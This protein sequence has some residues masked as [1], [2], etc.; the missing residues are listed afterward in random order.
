VVVDRPD[1]VPIKELSPKK[2]AEVCLAAAKE[3]DAQ[4]HEAE[5]IAL[6]ER[7]RGHNAA[8]EDISQRLAVLYD[9]QG[10]STKAREEYCKALAESPRDADLLNDIGYFFYQRGQWDDAEK[11]LKQAIDSEPKHQRAWTNL[12]L[13]YGQQGHYQL[14]Y[15]AFCKVVSPAAAHSNVGA[16]LAQNGHHQ[17]ADQALRQ[18]LA[19]EPDLQQSHV[20][21]AHLE[22]KA[23]N[24]A[25][26]PLPPTAGRVAMQPGGPAN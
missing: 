7:A 3:L 11:W 8:V 20:I 23:T 4:G 22:T 14:S 12:G 1:G 16:M 13:V 15:A 21:L 10:N 9:R 18:A 5:A 19:L 25:A 2:A 17:L 26:T 6:Y 24:P